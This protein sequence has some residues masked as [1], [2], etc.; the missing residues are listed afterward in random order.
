MVFFLVPA[1]VLLF[2]SGVPARDVASGVLL[3]SCAGLSFLQWPLV[4]TWY[5]CSNR[6]SRCVDM[7]DLAK[8]LKKALEQGESTETVNRATA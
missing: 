1:Q 2:G 6:R 8:A 4:N 3:E 5:E 7:L